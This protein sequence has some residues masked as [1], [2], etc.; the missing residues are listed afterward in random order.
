[1]TNQQLDEAIARRWHCQCSASDIQRLML[2]HD[3]FRVDRARVM[4]GIRRHI[5]ATTENKRL[6]RSDIV[7]KLRLAYRRLVCS[8]GHP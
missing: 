7:T 6:G 8:L 5:D 3:K 2:E 1:M 4:A